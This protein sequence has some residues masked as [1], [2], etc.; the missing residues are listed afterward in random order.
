MPA[1][2]KAALAHGEEAVGAA[3]G[4]T[5]L[6]EAVV[7]GATVPGALALGVVALGAAA[8]GVAVCRAAAFGAA[9][10]IV[11]PCLSGVVGRRRARA[12]GCHFHK[13]PRCQQQALLAL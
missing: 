1:G 5:A 3:L 10:F 12:Y 13:F 8:R 11:Y 7:P 2:H 9:D 6:V 4:V